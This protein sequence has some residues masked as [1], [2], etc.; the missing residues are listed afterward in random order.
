MNK[1][2]VK[3]IHGLETIMKIS[4]MRKPYNIVLLCDAENGTSFKP[5]PKDGY[6][7]RSIIQDIAK[8]WEISYQEAK[9]RYEKPDYCFARFNKGCSFKETNDFIKFCESGEDVNKGTFTFGSNRP[10]CPFA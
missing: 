2:E 9:K 7:K 4:W 5:Y 1:K 10:S 8:Y 3:Q 6:E